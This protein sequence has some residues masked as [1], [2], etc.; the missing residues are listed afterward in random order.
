VSGHWEGGPGEGGDGNFA[1]LRDAMMMRPGST[2]FDV[3]LFPLFFFLFPL[4]F[5]FCCVARRNHVV[6]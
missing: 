6:S 1:V 4:I 3:R 2:V 5:P